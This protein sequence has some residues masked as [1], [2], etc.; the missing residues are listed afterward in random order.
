MKF[1]RMEECA[2]QVVIDE[3]RE[4][5]IEEIWERIGKEKSANWRSQACELMRSV[6]LKSALDPPRIERKT[7]L[8]A[9]SKAKYGLLQ[10]GETKM[11]PK[12][13]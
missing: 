7:K 8:G 13:P 3:R 2:R 5:S 11:D 6:C 10:E 12:A 4:V 1:S 9:G